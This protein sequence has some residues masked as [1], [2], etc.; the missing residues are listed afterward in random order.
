[1]WSG[2]MLFEHKRCLNICK[3]ERMIVMIIDTILSACDNRYKK[4]G[5]QRCSDCSYEGYC[6]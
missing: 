3:C 5:I 4:R 1:M 2:W 6:R